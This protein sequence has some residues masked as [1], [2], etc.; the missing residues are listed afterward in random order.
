[1]E[2][3]KLR[4]E[5]PVVIV[6]DGLVASGGYMMSMGASHTIAQ[7]S[8]LVGNVGVI[9]FAGPLI[10][11][12]PSEDVIVT[13]PFKTAGSTRAGMDRD[14]RPAQIGLRQDGYHR[15]G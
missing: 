5:K 2:T 13:G 14:G 10:A 4:E 7:T 8:S 6:M 1:M 11:P 3:R 12:F 15:A 9:S